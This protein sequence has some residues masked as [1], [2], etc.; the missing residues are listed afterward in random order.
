M[1]ISLQTTCKQI[2]CVETVLTLLRVTGVSLILPK[3]PFFKCG[4]DYFGHMIQS[5]SLAVSDRATKATEG[6][7]TPSNVSEL[8]LF[9]G[10]CNVN[11]ALCRI[12]LE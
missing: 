1:V 6:F 12:S 3:C 11:D 7:Q 4:I 8:R 5:Q 2:I 9:L 10:L